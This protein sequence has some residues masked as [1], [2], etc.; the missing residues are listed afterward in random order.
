MG[1]KNCILP[2]IS[3]YL[4]TVFYLVKKANIHGSVTLRINDDK[5]TIELQ[6]L[7]HHWNHEKYVRDRGSSS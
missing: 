1:F 5:N 2:L 6:W 3:E 4:P 7:E